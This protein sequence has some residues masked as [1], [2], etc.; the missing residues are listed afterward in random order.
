MLMSK[1]RKYIRKSQITADAAMRKMRNMKYY[2][3]HRAMESNFNNILI[4][5]LVAETQLMINFFIFIYL[6]ISRK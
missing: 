5:T 6:H 1:D 2:S 4:P 3:R